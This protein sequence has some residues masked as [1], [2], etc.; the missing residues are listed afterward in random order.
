MRLELFRQ[1]IDLYINQTLSEEGRAKFF[2]AYAQKE[3]EAFEKKWTTATQGKAQFERFA[4][5]QSVQGFSEST[6]EKVLL[7]RVK[8]LGVTVDRALELFNLFTKVVTG[9]Y[10]AQTFVFVEG[11]RIGASQAQSIRADAQV[12][13]VNLSPFAR[14]AEARGFNDTAGS[15]FKNGLF[16]SIAAILKQESTVPVRFTFEGNGDARLPAIKI[17][18]RG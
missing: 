5:G 2:V 15:G 1:E 10:R 3:F 7:E 4:D 6:R 11:N 17:G 13:I 9:D 14:K 8:M 18:G 12:S 16:E